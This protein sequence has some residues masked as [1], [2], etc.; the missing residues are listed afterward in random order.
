MSISE[1]PVAIVT[2]GSRG[3]GEAT[4]I[5]LAKKGWN[6]T[7]T[8][9]SSIKDANKVVKK[10]EDL[11][12]EALALSADVSEDSSCRET[13]SQTLDKWGRID[14]LVNNAGTTKFVFDHSD[15]EGLD[16][17]DFLKIYKVNVVGPFPVS[18]THLTLP[19][20]YSV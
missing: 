19:T 17:Q 13:A 2:G 12:A 14:S 7:I 9:T 16:A 8:C 11:G 18:Y 10:C 20:I 6:V 4:A 1:K 5:F 15:L 3:V